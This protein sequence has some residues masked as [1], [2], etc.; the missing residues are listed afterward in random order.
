[1]SFCADGRTC[2][3]SSVEDSQ[4]A[5][6]IRNYTSSEHYEK[7]MFPIFVVYEQRFQNQQVLMSNSISLRTMFGCG[8]KRILCLSPHLY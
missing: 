1:M 8:G 2:R 5:K 3:T 6:L 7:R 4:Y